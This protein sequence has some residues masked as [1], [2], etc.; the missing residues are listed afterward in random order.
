M[1]AACHLVISSRHGSSV[2]MQLTGSASLRDLAN[3]GDL[4][5]PHGL[6]PADIPV[7]IALTHS[8]QDLSVLIHV[9]PP[10]GHGFSPI[11]IGRLAH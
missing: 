9:E 2:D 10:I 6:G 1:P 11:K 3:L 5:A 8:H 7:G 4:L